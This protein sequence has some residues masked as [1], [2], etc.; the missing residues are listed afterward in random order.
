MIFE[1]LE[2][3]AHRFEE[4]DRARSWGVISLRLPIWIVRNNVMDY[5]FLNEGF[6]GRQ[7]TELGLV[8][9]VVP[10]A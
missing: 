9:K 3:P 8:S 4:D 1:M 2:V 6:N 7:A 5:M 10:D